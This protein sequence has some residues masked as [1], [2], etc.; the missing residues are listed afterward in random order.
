MSFDH[1]AFLTSKPPQW[2]REYQKAVNK[3]RL[4]N[5]RNN[6][7]PQA[8]AFASSGRP[9]SDKV[10]NQG[11]S[12]FDRNSWTVM[13]ENCT[14]EDVYNLVIQNNLLLF[15]SVSLVHPDGKTQYLGDHGGYQLDSAFLNLKRSFPF[16]GCLESEQTDIAIFQ[17]PWQLNY[18]FFTIESKKTKFYLQQLRR[19]CLQQL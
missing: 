9:S 4:Y 19:L 14:T 1:F 15:G 5:Q 10:S 12:K 6:S 16:F 13:P 11:R 3:E 8:Q 17:C 2:A 18:F 7:W